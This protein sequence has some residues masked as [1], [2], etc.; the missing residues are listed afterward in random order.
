MNATLR[1]HRF[2]EKNSEIFSK[3][4]RSQKL[5]YLGSFFAVLSICWWLTPFKDVFVATTATWMIFWFAAVASDILSVYQKVWDTI[6]GKAVLLLSY[7]LLTNFA[8]GISSQVVNGIVKFQS[9]ALIYAINYV[10]VM[11]TPLFIF[12]S[13][14]LIFLALILCSQ[15]YWFFVITTEIFKKNRF[16]AGV[17][18][19]RIES[20][21]KA[22][23]AVRTLAF[24]VI[25][26]AAWGF[27]PYIAPRY[28]SFLENSTANFIYSFEASKYTRC[29][30]PED[31]KGIH[32]NDNEIVVVKKD[33]DNYTFTPLKCT[34]LL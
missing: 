29:K 18:P 3:L 1:T 11:L 17:M 2:I 24:I 31:T 30:I 16:F 6:L 4:S 5:Y 25:L 19:D 13:T 34:P 26:S 14:Y 27:R 15:L 10:A 20:Y 28:A 33:N 22:T 8:Y 32:I 7:A 9:N 23:F 21:P 12:I